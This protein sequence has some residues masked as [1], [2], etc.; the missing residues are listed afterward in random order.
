[1]P[2]AE[3]RV[4]GLDNVPLD[5]PLATAASRS[6]AAFVDYFILG[7]TTFA[8]FI[9][10]MLANAAL[11]DLGGPR[12]WWLVALALLGYFVLEYGYFAL[13]EIYLDGQTPGKRLLGL[14]VVTRAGGRPGAGAFLVRNTVRSVDLLVGVPFMALDALNRRLGDRL[15]GTLVVRTASRRAVAPVVLQRV[16]QGWQAREIGIVESFL[17][18]APGLEPARAEALAREVLD[19]IGRA[20]PTLAARAE[21]GV[22]ALVALRRLLVEDAGAGA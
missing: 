22:P 2:G 10:A 19:A 20:D 3:E 4:L 11:F 16:P 12:T 15:A 18:S 9:V 5:L 8:L 21:A 14:R 13:F 7:A 17:R 1:V 6:L